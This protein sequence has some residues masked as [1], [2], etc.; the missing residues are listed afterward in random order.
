MDVLRDEFNNWLAW[1]YGPKIK[2]EYDR[3]A[4]E[5]IQEDRGQKYGTSPR[6]I[7]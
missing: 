6:P 5:A 3:D 2:L 1:L 7:G 4:I